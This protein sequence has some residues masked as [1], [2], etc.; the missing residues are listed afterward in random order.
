[1]RSYITSTP[2]R[3]ALSYLKDIELKQDPADPR[4]FELVFVSAA[5]PPLSSSVPRLSFNC[6]RD[7]YS[8]DIA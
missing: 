4:P 2:D 5:K 6:M 1:M 8:A 3:Q 7:K